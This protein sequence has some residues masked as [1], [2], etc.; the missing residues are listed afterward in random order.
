[1]RGDRG[2]TPKSIANFIYV[3]GLSGKDALYFEVLVMFNQA[4][5][6][7]LKQRQLERIVEMRLS[8]NSQDLRV[9]RTKAEMDLASSW[10]TIPILVMLDLEGF[11]D[12]PAWI[13]KTLGGGVT[14]VQVLA[15]LDALLIHGIVVRQGG[16]LVASHSRLE[17]D[18]T[19]SKV[20]SATLPSPEYHQEMSQRAAAATQALPMSELASALCTVSAAPEDLP[21]IRERLVETVSELIALLHKRPGPKQLYQLSMTFFPLLTPKAKKRKISR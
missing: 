7:D 18:L 9:I 5:G 15:A 17:F 20:R 19:A 4:R 6:W 3:L 21:L 13:A 11:K 12:D 8:L 16:R 2:L 1:M 10:Y 14:E